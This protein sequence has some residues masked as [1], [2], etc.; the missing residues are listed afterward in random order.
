MS[1]L[2]AMA[3]DEIK[4]DQSFVRGLPNDPGAVAI[5]RSLITL[6]RGLKLDVIA[7][8]IETEEQRSALI[9]L[10]CRCVQGFLFSTAMS[11]DDFEQ[12]LATGRESCRESMCQT[13]ETSVC[14]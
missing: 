7:E 11:F 6:S 13:H 12:F 1:Q 4:I 3:I 14:I 10:G 8:G 2:Q 5:V 9:K